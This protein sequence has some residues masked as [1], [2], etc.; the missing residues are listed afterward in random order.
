LARLNEVFTVP[1]ILLRKP[2]VLK[3]VPFKYVTMYAMIKRGE[4]PAPIKIGQRAVAWK[5]SEIQAWIESRERGA[6]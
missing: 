3:I 1:E 5:M 4:F 2:E 6:A